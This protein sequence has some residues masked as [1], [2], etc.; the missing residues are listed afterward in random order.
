MILEFL[1]NKTY[2]KINKANI[3][4]CTTNSIGVTLSFLKAFGVSQ[5][6]NNI[7]IYGI[8]KK[9]PNFLK[10]N[11]FQYIFKKIELLTLS[12]SEYKF[13]KSLFLTSKVKYLP[14]GVDEE[15]WLPKKRK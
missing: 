7:Y 4:I 5:I 13:L 3:V 12:K 10:L 6:Q 2:K 1:L 8:F 15:F 9:K 11:I 14:F